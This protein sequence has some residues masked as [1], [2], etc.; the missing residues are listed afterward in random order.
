L[1]PNEHLLEINRSPE[2]TPNEGMFCVWTDFDF[3]LPIL[4]K[5][6]I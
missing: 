1:N 3:G 2:M 6:L 5:I 4:H